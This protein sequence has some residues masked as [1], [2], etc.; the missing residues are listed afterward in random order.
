MRRGRIC[1]AQ[2]GSG[3]LVG[4]VSILNCFKVATCDSKGS[5]QP[6][7]DTADYKARFLFNPQNL[8][9]HQLTDTHILDKW[10]DVYA[11]ELDQ[12][13]PYVSPIPFHHKKGAIIWAKLEGMVQPTTVT[14]LMFLLTGYTS[15]LLVMV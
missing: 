15:H 1:I 11:S 8:Q 4:E 10:S 7:S 14:R 6:C 5:W 13:F 3:L 9:K 2:S 12:P